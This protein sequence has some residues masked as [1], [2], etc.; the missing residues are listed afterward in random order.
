M[1]ALIWAMQCMRNLHQ[2]HVIFATDCF[3]LMKMVSEQE[4]W[5]AFESYMHDIRILKTSFISSEIIHV[6]R[7]ENQKADS[8]ARSARKQSSFIV[9]MDAELPV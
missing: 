8:L 6:L 2:F 9:H 4:E 3:Q 7:T 1:E 5:P